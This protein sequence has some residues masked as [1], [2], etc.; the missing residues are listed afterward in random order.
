MF[1]LIYIPIS[2]YESSALS[3]FHQCLFSDAPFLTDNLRQ[4]FHYLTVM[5][6]FKTCY[7]AII[8]KATLHYPETMT[9]KEGSTEQAFKSLV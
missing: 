8:T 3:A 7:Q 4:S 1:V 6:N 9:P 2:M 5:L